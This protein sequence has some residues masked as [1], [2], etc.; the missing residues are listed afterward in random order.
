MDNVRERNSGGYII[1]FF[2]EF[3]PMT[4]ASDNSSLLSNQD[5][6][7]FLMQARIEP[8]ISYSTIKDFTS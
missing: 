6:D 5:I 8:Q 3:Q 4:S 7:Q 1:L 2:R